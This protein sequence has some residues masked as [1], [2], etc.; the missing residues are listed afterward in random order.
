MKLS[1]VI[2]TLNRVNYL[3]KCIKSIG[4]SC[5]GIEN[6]VIVVDGGSTDGTLEWC[7]KQPIYLI[8]QGAPLGAVYAYN[9][10]FYAAEGE[11]VAA[12]NDDCVVMGNTLKLACDYLDAHPKTGQVA[13]PWKDKGDRDLRVIHVALGRQ[14]F[15]AIYANFGV[16][17]RAAGDAVNWWGEWYHYGGDCELSF[18]LIMAGWDVDELVGGEI[19]HYRV[20]D[21]T[22]RDNPHNHDFIRKWTSIDVSHVI[23]QH[24]SMLA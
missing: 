12:I 5:A 21:A 16:T 13:I 6:E 20:K 3:T 10:G 18:N 15:D 22:R 24:K 11:Y 14:Q 1:I 9:T 23:E 2:A 7:R 17:R 4:L 8:E 19:I